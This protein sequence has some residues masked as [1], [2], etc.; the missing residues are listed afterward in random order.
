V[1]LP[2]RLLNSYASCLKPVKLVLIRR[3]TANLPRSCAAGRFLPLIG[4][5]ITDCPRCGAGEIT[6]DILGQV[7][8]SKGT[9]G[10]GSYEIFCRCRSCHR[11]T[12]FVVH[13][14]DIGAV[15]TFDEEG[16]L[17]S[18][19]YAI[20]PYFEI[21]EY[22]SLRNHISVVPPDYLPGNIKSAF[23]EGASCLSIEC[24]NAAAVMF[25]LSQ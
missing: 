22:I 18:Y 21:E 7:K 12:T 5:L 23:E 20:N 4:L 16:A 25:R 6:L 14:T 24:F 9:N 8:V 17:L 11:A 19:R 3:L 13:L 10:D 1:A 2:K 15:G